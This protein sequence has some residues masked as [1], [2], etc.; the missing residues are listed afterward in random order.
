MDLALC[1]VEAARARPAVGSAEHGARATTVPHAGELGAEQIQCLLPGYRYELV[2]AAPPDRV[3]VRARASRGAP[4]A[5]QRGRD[6]AGAV[7]SSA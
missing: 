3:P 1:V 6:A 7:E 4:S 5:G 2:A